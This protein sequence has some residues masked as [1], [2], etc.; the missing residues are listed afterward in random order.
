MT[1]VQVAHSD[2]QRTDALPVGAG[3]LSIEDV[4][5][6]ARNGQRVAPLAPEAIARVEKTAAWVADTVEQIARPRANGQKAVAYYG[7]NTGF[8]AQAGRSVLDAEYLIQVL[9]RNLIASHSVGV[10]PYFDEAVVRA[11][12]LIRAQSLTEGYSGV[13]P[14]S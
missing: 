12:L 7:I 10:G 11:V 6:V 4:V 2:A 1:P 3:P 14:R 13:R 9:G 8:G 5:H